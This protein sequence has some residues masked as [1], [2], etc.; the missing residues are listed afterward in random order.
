MI[1]KAIY[2]AN[3]IYIDVTNIVNKLD[4]EFVVSN[5]N[6]TDPV[7]GVVKHLTIILS[8]GI[9]KTYSENAKINKN[10]LECKISPEE[11]SLNMSDY[12]HIVANKKGLEIGGPSKSFYD[13]GIYRS[14]VS[15][16]NVVFDVCADKNN[17]NELYKFNKKTIPG[18]VYN[19]DVTNLSIFKNESYDFVFASHILEHLVNPLQ[20]LKEITRILK[21]NGNCILVL[22]WKNNTAD[23]K[24]N[25]TPFS[26]L[27]D[28]YNNNRDETDVRDHLDDIIRNYDVAIDPNVDTISQVVER[29]LDHY[30]N[31]ELN[32]H[33]FDFQLIKQCL[34][35]FN[36]QL[37]EVQLI[38][39]Y[40]QIIL[41]RLKK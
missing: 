8:S 21:P 15:L 32:V 16:D 23:H 6:F 14:P 18:F 40:H 38:Y 22:P 37:D 1:T 19:A 4:N 17:T 34:E 31:R 26:E 35:F 11:C 27:L 9:S 5:D 2:G 36:Y 20:A 41:A 30:V 24:R 7:F 33:V 28:H 29:S 12:S 39:P 25:V 3:D 13:M 10:I